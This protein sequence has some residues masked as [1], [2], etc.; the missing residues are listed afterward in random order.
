MAI[1]TTLDGGFRI[2]RPIITANGVV[3]DVDPTV[4]AHLDELNALLS[5]RIFGKRDETEKERSALI[6]RLIGAPLQPKRAPDG[7]QEN[8]LAHGLSAAKENLTSLT[9]SEYIDLVPNL[10]ELKYAYENSLSGNWALFDQNFKFALNEYQA[11]RDYLVVFAVN[12][13]KVSEFNGLKNF[14]LNNQ[15][16]VK[17]VID[18][19]TVSAARTYIYDQKLVVDKYNED[20]SPVVADIKAAGLSLTQ[21]AFIPTVKKVVNAFIFN[22]KQAAILA[23]AKI[24]KVPEELKPQLIQMMKNSRVEITPENVNFFLPLFVT[25]LTGAP[26]AVDASTPQD[27]DSADQDFAVEP[28]Q[29]TDAVVQVSRSAVRCAA[30]LFYGMVVGD[31]LDVFS[32]VNYFTHNYLLRGGIE[33]QDSTLRDDLQL[34]VF[35]NRFI[36]LKTQKIADRT[37]PAERQMFYKQVFNAGADLSSDSD[38]AQILVPNP[39]FPKLWKVLVLETAKYIER[40]QAAFY[41]DSYVSRQNVMQAV[42]DLQYNL[43][44][45]CIGMVNVVSPLIYAELNFVIKRIFM[46]DEVMRQIVPAGATWWR[47]VETLYLA[48]R[49]QRPRATV[50]YNKAKLGHDIIR[51][52]AEYD[53]ATFEDNAKFSAFVSDVEAFI[54]TQS[55]LQQD[56]GGDTDTSD[57]P[58]DSQTP[59]VSAGM[60]S[61]RIGGYL[62]EPPAMA[63]APTAGGD[64]NGGSNGASGGEWDF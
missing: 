33:I 39:E 46:H 12:L 4:K 44:T 41:P 36:D 35:S 2:Q 22:G 49:N 53:P 48:M 7:W 43:S 37:R 60:P 61:N 58:A 40:A 38:L 30:Q 52:I 8:S 24:G 15:S 31:E 3:S 45:H 17:A 13:M 55:I 1:N 28:F 16:G 47:V 5:K 27:A 64:Q 50:L 25:Q 11:I 19:A 23:G 57:T 32:T 10:S 29:D 26:T 54:T 6:A 9:L 42:E 34:Y 20:D 56:E 59:G 62:R 63:T 18:Y 14:I 21:A 51:K